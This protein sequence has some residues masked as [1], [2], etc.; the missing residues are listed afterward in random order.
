MANKRVILWGP[1]GVGEHA[2]RFLRASN[3][4]ELVGARCYSED[5]EGKDVGVLLGSSPCGVLATRDVP[6]L[7]AMDA[8]CV[9]FTPRATLTDHTLPN[10]PDR[11][12]VDDLLAILA[13]GKNVVSS[14]GSPIH[15]RHLAFGGPFLGDVATACE[16]GRSSAF[17]TGIDP[18]F[19][20][21][22]LGATLGSMVGEIRQMR[23]W[24]MIDYSTYMVPDTIAALGFGRKPD[25]LADGQAA[26]TASWSSSLWVLA[27]ACGVD[28]DDITFDADVWLSPDAYTATNGLQ[29]EPGTVGALRW[30]LTGIVKGEPRLQLNH[31]NRLGAHAAP[32]WP[33]IGEAGGYRIEIDGF[34]PIR[35][36]F[37][38]GLPGGTGK[39]LDDAMAMTAARLVNSIDSVVAAAPGFHTPNSLPLI[40]PRYSLVA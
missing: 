3:E 28:L 2:L 34:P 11:A 24:E 17:F 5:K 12:W 8:E 6:A 16:R 29:V 18:G 30:S 40:G 4:L 13:S 22:V 25:E 21:C 35:A 32:D 37:P 27:D 19:S 31:V 23:S 33:A 7:L 39:G 15:W 1:G 38:F 20:D 14:I 36:D 26:V 9:I 10:S